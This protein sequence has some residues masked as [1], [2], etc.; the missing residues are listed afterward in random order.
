MGSRL[1]VNGRCVVGRAGRLKRQNS[2]ELV[3]STWGYELLPLDSCLRFRDPG[4]QV[5]RPLRSSAACHCSHFD[6]SLMQPE[7]CPI[8]IVVQP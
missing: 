6:A 2:L 7:R 8:L 5:C 4:L 3:P 1:G